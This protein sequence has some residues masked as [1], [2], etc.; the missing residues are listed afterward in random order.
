[1]NRPQTIAEYLQ[2]LRAELRGA[3]PA[4]IQDAIYDAE[5]HLRS[6]LAEHPEETEAAMLD[7]VAGSYGAPAEVAEIYRD[8]EIKVQRALRAPQPR[9]GRGPLARF[10]GVIADGRSYAALFYMLLALATGIFYFTWVVTGLSLS[11]GLS[12]L[13]VGIPFT[14][15]FFASVRL[16]ALVEGRLVEV[17]LGVRMPRRPASAAHD[18]PLLKRIG[19]MF[20]DPR[21]WGTL[22]YMFLMLPLGILYFTVA[23]AGI[24]LSIALVAAPIAQLFGY[25]PTTI[26]DVRYFWPIWTLPLAAI[27]GV[28]VLF[29]VLHA[30]RGIGWLHGH[31][32]K[33]LLVK[34]GG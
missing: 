20:V 11:A 13:I 5:E 12:V 29:L 4:M 26:N 19:A 2:Q 31:L 33:H 23:V 3:D 27:G 25:A 10:F 22:F 6:E 34:T 15:L 14:I 9:P 32:A 30:A 17:M 7:R 24:S 1:M 16:L 8:T 18:L 28:L 21:T